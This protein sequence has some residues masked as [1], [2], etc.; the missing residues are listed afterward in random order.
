MGCMSSKPV[1][2][3]DKDA[4]Q[5]T[6]RIEKTLKNDKKTLDRTIKILLLG[7][8][9][10]NITQ[11]SWKPS[12]LTATLQV[13]ESLESRQSSSKCESSI[14]GVFLMKSGAKHAR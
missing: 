12:R 2:T 6:A 3:A 8:Y 5:R 10:D 11:P 14:R 7:K 13:P 4:L 9:Q 1:D